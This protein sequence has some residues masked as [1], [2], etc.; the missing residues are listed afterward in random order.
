MA[1][2]TITGRVG[3]QLGT[4]GV[5]VWETVTLPTG[6]SFDK[7]WAVWGKP[8][9]PENAIVEVRGTGSWKVRPYTKQDGTTSN[10][11]DASINDPEIKIIKPATTTA[12]PMPF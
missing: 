4:S 2:V 3:K 12:D 6:Q 11:I 10:A 7:K 5:E 8:E 9:Q 1:Y